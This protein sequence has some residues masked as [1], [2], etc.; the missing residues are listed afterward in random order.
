M[1]PTRCCLRTLLTSCRHYAVGG[2]YATKY[3]KDAAQASSPR[4]LTRQ[5]PTPSRTPRL[6]CPS[7]AA[8][9]SPP[10]TGAAA[11]ERA[12]GVG[13]S[14]AMRCDRRGQISQPHLCAGK[15]AG[16]CRRVTGWEEA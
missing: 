15:G 9:Q 3:A 16:A 12:E 13:I 14:W 1:W 10:P 7:H 8:A 6:L 11:R 5:S 2:D 4:R